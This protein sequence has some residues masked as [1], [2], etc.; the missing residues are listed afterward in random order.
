MLEMKRRIYARRPGV[1]F[2]QVPD[3]GRNEN[4]YQTTRWSNPDELPAQKILSTVFH[5]ESADSVVF[6]AGG[7][8]SSSSTCLPSVEAYDIIDGCRSLH[9]GT[10]KI[11]DMQV[12]PH[13][14]PIP[15]QCSSLTELV[16][17]AARADL[18]LVGTR[19]GLL[20]A[21]G[22]RDGP[23][24]HGTVEVCDVVANSWSLSAPLRRP[25]SAVAA[26]VCGGHIFAIGGWR[27]AEAAHGG[28]A[29]VEV[30]TPAAARA[31]GEW[32]AAA[33]MRA[34]RA[35]PGAAALGGRIYV[36]GGRTAA[37]EAYDPGADT[38][39][40]IASLGQPRWGPSACADPAYG[41]VLAV[42]GNLWEGA[43][44]DSA[45]S[46]DPREGRWRPLPPLPFEAWGAAAVWCAGPAPPRRSPPS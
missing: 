5:L 30:L 2:L 3:T 39:S 38:W 35:F 23:H 20:F 36:L 34:G 17:Q 41:R 29:D 46:F 13:V 37:A 12:R 26:V 24:D 44:L 40:A 19:Q 43:S 21:I 1:E 15:A 9:P 18:A 31:G 4:D 11:P 16:P 25:R 22:G 14:L 6:V 7:F 10:R 45:E 8:D 32:A 27:Q 42:G 28:L 33:P